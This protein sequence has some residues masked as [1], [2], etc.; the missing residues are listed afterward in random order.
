MVVRD[1]DLQYF[2]VHFFEVYFFVSCFPTMYLNRTKIKYGAMK[3]KAYEKIIW[4]IELGTIYLLGLKSSFLVH[5][6]SAL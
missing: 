5:S 6:E 2:A 1:S 3:L 4:M